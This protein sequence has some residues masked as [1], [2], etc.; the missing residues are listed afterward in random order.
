M[1]TDD[2][3]IFSNEYQPHSL[4]GAAYPKLDEILNLSTIE[5][6]PA[7]AIQFLKKC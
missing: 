1:H 6:G 5:G 3:R 2:D 4:I 7:L